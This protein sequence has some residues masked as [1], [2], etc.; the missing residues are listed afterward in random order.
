MHGEKNSLAEI[1]LYDLISDV[2]VLLMKML[3]ICKATTDN[4]LGKGMGRREGTV[5]QI[6]G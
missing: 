5:W 4:C 3:A 6:I 1:L 2:M